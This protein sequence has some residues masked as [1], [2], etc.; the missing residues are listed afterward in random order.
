M[1][2]EL[3]FYSRQRYEIFLFSTAFR[4]PL[5]PTQSPDLWVPETLSLGAKRHLMKWLRMVELYLH[6]SIHLHGVIIN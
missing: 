3:G 1:A 5:G 4:L 2:E 6:S